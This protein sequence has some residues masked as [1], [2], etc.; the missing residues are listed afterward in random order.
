MLRKL[1]Q[2]IRAWRDRG[3]RRLG[4]W[5]FD[6]LPGSAN[7]PDWLQCQRIL[8]IR[9]DAK[10]GDAIVSSFLF[11]ALR[12]HNP[13]VSIE[14]I[15]SSS[16]RAL[17]Q[18]HWQADAVYLAPKRPGYFELASLAREIGQVDL[19]VHL[20][21]QM[22]PTDLFFLKKMRAPHVAALD[23]SPQLVT[24]R[25]RAATQGLHFADKLKFLLAAGGLTDID[26]HYVLPADAHSEAAVTAFWPKQHCKVIAINPHG[27]GRARRLSRDSLDRLL[28]IVTRRLPDCGMCLLFSPDSREE[29]ASIASHWA[30]RRVFTY[31]DSQTIYDVMA[32]LRHCH[33]LISVDTA[34]IHMAAALDLPVL[35][36]YN[37]DKE[38]YQ[39]WGP[40]NEKSVT[41]FSSNSQVHDINNLPWQ[42][43]EKAVDQFANRF[44]DC[45]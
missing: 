20:T 32:Q 34:T 16:M 30:T 10:I 12:Q 24:L 37:P 36:L 11:R 19:I 39:D 7:K 31:S 1:K 18:D 22:K 43:L 26:T 40:N 45:P 35:G 5:L 9:W 6:Y 41:L 23:D 13:N 17:F 8:L 25:L 4:L 38:N 14:V 27:A 44:I 29:M 33:G 15:C 21:K 28:E 3:R 2:E 42:E